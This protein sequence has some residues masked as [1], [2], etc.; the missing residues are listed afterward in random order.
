[1]LP[2]CC[3][4]A[5]VLSAGGGGKHSPGLA[6]LLSVGDVEGVLTSLDGEESGA[7][8]S[9]GSAMLGVGLNVPPPPV[10][11]VPDG[12]ELSDELGV[13]EAAPPSVL[14]VCEGVLLVLG[15]LLGVGLSVELGVIEGALLLGVVETTGVLLLGVCETVSSSVLGVLLAV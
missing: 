3:V 6:A 15:V 2:D 7:V 8:L 9:L 12:V 5:G 11:G 4:S 13:L 10:L 1:M 14:G